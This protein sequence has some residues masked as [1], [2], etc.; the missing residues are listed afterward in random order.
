M[1]RHRQRE[2]ALGISPDA[3]SSLEAIDAHIERHIG[4]VS[5]VFDEVVSDIIHVDIHLVPP[6][7]E[8]PFNTLVTSGMSDLPM[9][10]PP[11]ASSCSHAELVAL[12]PPDWPLSQEALADESNYWPLRQLK[13]L[14]RLP[15][16]HNTWL[17]CDH[18]VSNG[19]PPVPF[20]P[21]TELCC[22]L[23]EP[24]ISLPSEFMTL[25]TPGGKRIVFLALIPLYLEE[26]AHKLKAG[27]DALLKRFERAGIRDI[28]DPVRANVCKRSRRRWGWRN[29]A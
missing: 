26:N 18:T 20:A 16:E 5:L 12:L 6:A 4:P 3:Q 17:W 14:A 22:A 10:A 28:I 2:R 15:H 9:A 1:L 24:P 25:I 23:L 27:A 19:D 13:M 29:D 21:S 11:D 8:R 7:P